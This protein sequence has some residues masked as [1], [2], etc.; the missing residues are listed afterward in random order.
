MTEGALDHAKS[1]AFA[2]RMMGVLNNAALA[3][4]TSVGH[5]VG[6]FDVLAGL[7]AATSRQ[8]ADAAGLNER[9]VREWLG[10]MVT[11]RVVEYNSAG[12][13]YILP[14]E[15]AAWLTRAAGPNN[16][17]I[18]AQYIPLLASVEEPIVTCV[19]DGGGVPYSAY[20]R[21]QRLMAEDSGA[22]H[23]AALIDTILPLVPRLVERLHAGL[24][25]ADVGCGRGHAIN[26][27]ARAF[28]NSRFSGYDF[29]EEGIA[30]GREE[31]ARLG[32]TNT[33]FEA[34]DVATLD[35]HSQY[36]LITAFDAVHDQAR[37]AEVL[38][39][40]AE[41]LRPDG[42]FL[43]VDIGASGDVGENLDHP[44]GPFMYTVSCMHCMT[45]SLALGGAGLGAMWGEQ[46]ARRMLAEAGF[47]SIEVKRIDGDFFNYY[48]VATKR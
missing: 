32:L 40:I 6:L 35:L 19:R 47:A 26:L 27:M 4:L 21:F 24:D 38:R 12:A 18:S 23:D 41:A 13:T 44:L 39:G 9:Y 42:T 22:V 28:P 29:S 48:Y 46:T 7:P 30:A 34:R 2:E 11:G 17:A 31:A 5:Q 33:Q 20:P 16:L 37:P 1:D 14:P 43:M 25:A 36:D 8:I 45:V 10:A 15:H 3:L